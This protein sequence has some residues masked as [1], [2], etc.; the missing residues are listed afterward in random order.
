MSIDDIKEKWLF[1]AYSAKKQD[2]SEVDF[3]DK[4]QK[5]RFFAG[6]KGIGRFSADRLGDD[7]TL[8]TKQI[9][10]NEIQQI[11]V[12]WNRFN[13]QKEKFESVKIDYSQ[14]DTYK[15]PFPK[16]SKKGTILE[17][18]GINEWDR[19]KKIRL[20]HSLEKLI[21]PSLNLTISIFIYF[22]KMI[23]NRSR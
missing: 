3:R 2:D 22:P 23:R 16:K 17:I 4:I 1:V 14:L 8:T 21:N 11:S 10:S 12:N 13:N 5:R 6:A 9:D 15:I 20:K 18:S 19:E 7:L